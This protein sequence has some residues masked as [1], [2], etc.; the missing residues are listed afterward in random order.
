MECGVLIRSSLCSALGG[1]GVLLAPLCG[2]LVLLFGL[3]FPGWFGVGEVLGL[4]GA[5][6]FLGVVALVP[7][8]AASAAAAAAL[9][10]C[11]VYLGAA[12]FSKFTHALRLSLQFSVSQLSSPLRTT[13]SQLS[14]RFLRTRRATLKR[15]GVWS[16]QRPNHIHTPAGIQ[17]NNIEHC[18]QNGYNDHAFSFSAMRCIFR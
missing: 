18:K 17:K 3:V 16:A 4:S 10:Q 6:C 7:A 12:H 15:H 14:N 11:A 2:W 9:R 8:A 13:S 5:V 1:A